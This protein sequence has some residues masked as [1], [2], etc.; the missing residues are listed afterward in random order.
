L[1]EKHALATLHKVENK[2]H[3]KP[4]F[5]EMIAVARPMNLSGFAGGT[6]PRWTGVLRNC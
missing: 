2:F 3:V 1:N 6:G 4:G 5:E